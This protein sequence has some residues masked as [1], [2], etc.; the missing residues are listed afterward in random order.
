MTVLVNYV[1]DLPELSVYTT[2]NGGITAM[3]RSQARALG[4]G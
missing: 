3:T 2:A 1:K 4:P